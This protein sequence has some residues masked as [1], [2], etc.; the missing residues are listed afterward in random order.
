M[1]L[2]TVTY[3]GRPVPMLLSD[4]DAVAAGLDTATG[5]AWPPAASPASA[6]VGLLTPGSDAWLTAWA[7]RIADLLTGTITRDAQ[8]VV[9]SA[10]IVWPD[11]RPGTFTATPT[12]TGLLDGWTATYVPASGATATVTQPL[13]TR[14]ANGAVTTR[15]ALTIARS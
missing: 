3:L 11:G 7:A 12:G 5:A 1:K 10:P 14:D 9:A 8:G 15:P 13:I 4:A 6:A 2:Y